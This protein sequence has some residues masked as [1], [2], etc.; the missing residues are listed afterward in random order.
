MPYIDDATVRRLLPY[1]D[2]VEAVGVAALQLGP[3]ADTP[4][5]AIRDVRHGQLL[6][7][8]AESAS[9]IGV[10]LSTV[11]PA[12]PE[13]GIP[14]VQGLYA[15]FDATTMQ[16]L[17]TIDA[18]ELTVIRTAATSALSS[19]YLSRPDASHLVI[20]GTGPQAWGHVLAHQAIRPIGT[21]GIVGRSPEGVGRLVERIETLGLLAY[22]ATADD[23]RSA[24]IVCTCTTAREPL[25]AGSA[26]AADAHVIA[27]GSHEPHVRELDAAT[28]RGANIVV[29]QRATAWREAGDLI[30]ARAEG[31]IDESSVVADLAELVGGAGISSPRRS[32]FKSV[33][34]A[35]E[36]LA[37]ASLVYERMHM[38]V[39]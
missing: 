38:G 25:F 19:R 18:T 14:R 11:A 10:K 31:A 33:G 35:F 20:F 29:E 34:M 36:D 16:T 3:G 9:Y 5:R 22:A 13:R 37:V 4:P 2:A 6:L 28:L 15:L 39:A 27:I 21:V 8:P 23:V 32:V 26:L 12:N 30:M 17:V 1:A 7:M 24:H